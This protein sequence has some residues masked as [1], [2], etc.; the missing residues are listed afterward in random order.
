MQTNIIKRNLIIMVGMASALLLLLATVMPALASASGE[1]RTRSYVAIGDSVAS[2]LGTGTIAGASSEDTLCGRSS[3]AYSEFVSEKLKHNAYSENFACQGARTTH[4]ANPQSIGG[5]NITP[6]L[7]AAFAKG[8]PALISLTIGANDAEWSTF[9]GACFA[10]DCNTRQYTD[11]ANAYLAQLSTSLDNSLADIEAR[12]HGKAPDVVVTGYFNS[13]SP[14]CVAINGITSGEIAWLANATEALN[15]LIKNSADKYK[16]A[17]FAPVDFT[18]HDIC[19][20]NTWIQRPG[21]IPG[22]PAPFHPTVEGQQAIARTVL[23][24]AGKNPILRHN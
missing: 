17:I 5:A 1:H 2:G 16:F 21:G 24:A 13:M 8:T 18:G 19:S 6:Q 23:A 11:L 4:L 14:N 10:T 12:S 3:N 15:S 9:I 7:D 20:A 22:E